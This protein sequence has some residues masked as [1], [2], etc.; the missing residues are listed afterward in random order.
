MAECL[1][2]VEVCEHDNAVRN[3]IHGDTEIP[4][5]RLGVYVPAWVVDRDL[6]FIDLLAIDRRRTRILVSSHCASR[7]GA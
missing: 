4:V 2:S 7:A 3:R 5:P 6:R 1:A